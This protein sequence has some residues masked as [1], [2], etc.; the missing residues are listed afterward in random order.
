MKTRAAILRGTGQD[1]EITELDLDGPKTGEVLIRYV[2]LADLPEDLV[3]QG[4]VVGQRHHEHV[5]LEHRPGVE[6]AHGD[7]VGEHHVSGV[8]PGDDVAEHAVGHAGTVACR[9][10]SR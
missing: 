10:T 3:G 4:D 9:V 7:V 2:T 5:A 6:E 8:V 1:F